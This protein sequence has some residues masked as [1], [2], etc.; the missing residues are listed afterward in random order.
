M[1]GQKPFSL[2]GFQGLK[3]AA[4]IITIPCIR[5]IRDYPLKGIYGVLKIC[6]FFG[7]VFLT[8]V[9]VFKAAGIPISCFRSVN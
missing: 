3:S 6:E 4:C 5:P 7:R 9:F 1:A 2:V 8:L